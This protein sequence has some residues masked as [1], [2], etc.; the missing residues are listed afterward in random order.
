MS[1]EGDA[2]CQNALKENGILSNK[3]NL[4][5]NNEWVPSRTFFL[6]SFPEPNTV[7][8][9]EWAFNKFSRQKL[10]KERAKEEM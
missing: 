9:I 7:S 8:Y 6:H 5:I 2:G 3:L 4:V 1:K 10:R